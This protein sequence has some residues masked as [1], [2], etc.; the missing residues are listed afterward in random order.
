MAPV[1][2][3]PVVDASPLIILA[4]GGW[5]ELLRVVGDRII[6]PRQV[7]IE[8]R[9]PGPSDA[10]ARALSATAWLEVVDTGPVVAEVRRFDL[11]P[12]EEAVLTWALAH[13]GAVAIVDER[14]GR[15]AARALGIP[16][17]GTLGLI[18]EAKLRGMIP[19]ARP[20]IAHLLH[21][22]SW[23]LSEHPREQAL[24]RAGE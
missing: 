10:V 22:T 17:V 20:V 3:P 1:A 4:Q 24:R 14:R 12:G 6:V 18:I 5:L 8:I 11:D 13:A 19:A 9:R 2:E 23:Y 15:R 7:S 16:V 21:T